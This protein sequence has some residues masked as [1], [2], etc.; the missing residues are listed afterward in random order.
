MQQF[1]TLALVLISIYIT[2]AQDCSSLLSG[3]KRFIF[4]DVYQHFPKEVKAVLP[5]N[6]EVTNKCRFD[7]LSL[8]A[9]DKQTMKQL[10][11]DGYHLCIGCGYSD[12]DFGRCHAI[13]VCSKGS[14]CINAHNRDQRPAPSYYFHG[15]CNPSD[16][17][18]ITGDDNVH[19]NVFGRDVT[20]HYIKKRCGGPICNENGYANETQALVNFLQSAAT[21]VSTLP[22]DGMWGQWG[23]WSACDKSC[24]LGVHT[25][26]RSCDSPAPMNGGA[27][28]AGEAS[29]TD[30]C[31]AFSC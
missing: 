29:Q 21:T 1:L 14:V 26:T 24:D 5:A 9:G 15:C 27:T 16:S 18:C 23:S 22:V 30:F 8:S 11:N 28:C 6:S 19:F 17:K 12:S 31:N 2:H 10:Y 25:K 7:L 20:L 3:K 4:D 13:D